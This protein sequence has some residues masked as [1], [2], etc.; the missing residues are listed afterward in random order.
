M[1]DD[2]FDKLNN[3]TTHLMNLNIDV[4]FV[5]LENLNLSDLISLA[6]TN[7]HFFRMA[8][9]VFKRKHS[10]KLIKFLAPDDIIKRDLCV[11]DD[12]IY[13]QRY[14]SIL[15]LL[16]HFG[17]LILKLNLEHGSNQELLLHARTFNM[18]HSVNKF[19]NFYCSE[20]L[21][22]LEIENYFANFFDEMTHPFK[23]VEKVSITGWFK[24]LGT[25]TLTF[26]E[27][28]PAIKHLVLENVQV[29]DSSSISR[30]F[31]Y[32]E[33]LQLEIRSSRYSDG[34][35]EHDV[36]QALKR[37]PQIRSL[38]LDGASE[39]ILEIASENLIKLEMLALSPLRTDFLFS[40]PQRNKKIVFEYVKILHIFTPYHMKNIKFSNLNE[41]HTA[42]IVTPDY[43]WIEDVKRNS[44]LKKLYLDRIC[45]GNDRLQ[46]IASA[47]LSVDQLSVDF[48]SDV[49]DNSIIGFIENCINIHKF[50]F[51]K[52]FLPDSPI[53]LRLLQ[54][55]FGSK[56]TIIDRQCEIT[57]E[58]E[59]NSI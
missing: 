12:V 37:N 14:D 19:T 40:E 22:Q 58:R 39:K 11:I 52:S 1:S 42:A 17:Q 9:N 35:A 53:T 59:Y 5:I 23:H 54:E 18:V 4:Q 15:R 8:A 27:L 6:D 49:D 44:H 20:G 45:V 48:C 38:N 28:F 21:T 47:N 43:D 24:K 29:I 30:S 51:K 10:Q 50:C 36:E 55:R 16:T 3:E 46:Q 25:S 13:V 41:L 34:F 26:D 33:H 32:L 31:S 2:R 56:L 7:A 57:V